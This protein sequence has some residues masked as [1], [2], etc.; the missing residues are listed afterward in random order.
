[1]TAIVPGQDTSQIKLGHWTIVKESCPC[2]HDR[3]AVGSQ[4]CS[5]DHRMIRYTRI[6]PRGDPSARRACAGAASLKRPYSGL[7]RPCP[8][9][10]HSKNVMSEIGRVLHKGRQVHKRLA[11]GPP[12]PRGFRR[13]SALLRL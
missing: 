7:T 12:R 8:H 3:T 9:L 1:M 4:T 5:C 13:A 11:F 2:D 6:V 10:P